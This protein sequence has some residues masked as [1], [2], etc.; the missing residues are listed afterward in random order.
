M[1]NVVLF[2]PTPKAVYSACYLMEI[3]EKAELPPGVIN[4]IPGEGSNQLIMFFKVDSFLFLLIS[5][6]SH[7]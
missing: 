7:L 5:H 6:L 4:F 1:G 3:L 2:K